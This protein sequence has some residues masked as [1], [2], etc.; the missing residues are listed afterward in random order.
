MIRLTI[1]AACLTACAAVDP[2]LRKPATPPTMPEGVLW[3]DTTFAGRG[4]QLYA[5]SWRPSGEVKAVLA[6][7]HGLAD[8]GSRY[9]VLA[10]RLAKAGYAVWAM[11]MRGHGRSAG[12]RVRA[13]AIDDYLDDVD[14]FMALIKSHDAGK[15]IYLMGHSLGGL[16]AST[17]EIDR[18][19]DLA[20]LILSAPGIAFDAPPLQAAVIQVIATIAPG[21]RVLA[22]P[23]QDF[24]S[25]QAVIDDMGKDELMFQGGGQAR[26][27]RAAIDGARRVW[28]H[29]ERIAIPLLAIAGSVDKIVAPTGSRDLV[30]RA[31]T[32]DAT[33][34][35]YD[36][37]NHDLMHEPGAERVMADVQA[38]LDAH[39]AGAPSTPPALPTQPL[40]G[41]R[42]PS[43]ASVELD[44]RGED[45]DG[46]GVTAGLR[47]RF[48]K[49]VYAGGIDLRAGA[50]PNGPGALYEADL[51]AL[52][53]GLHTRGGALIAIT[54]G[55]GIG[56]VR[57][58]SATHLPV[59]LS[60]E[61][62]VGPLRALARGGIGWRVS[63]D[64]YVTDAH[65]LA[66]EL[67]GLV[68]IRLGGDHRYW[69]RV[70]AGAGP[71]VG[72]TYRDLG[73]VEFYGVALGVDMWGAE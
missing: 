9:A 65:G 33:F 56:G 5:Q 63:G 47:A 66:D 51:H 39:V 70:V 29:P 14:A 42:G 19:P 11:D 10:E 37:F 6:I 57:G 52:G 62:P 68:A 59:E 43:S 54:G 25:S 72:V 46:L 4:V 58:A 67:S 23:H 30:A 32:K 38:W 45:H 36:G 64:R 49:G 61:A 31:G 48:G 28:A 50:F 18:H 20:G 34:L 16:I 12:E 17:Y 35:L 40:K 21:A 71:Y 24:S 27:A 26:T 41:D 13:D 1:L 8:H 44:V 15:P 53:V 3:S 22:T 69:S 73:G 7:H 60:L 55:I 2:G